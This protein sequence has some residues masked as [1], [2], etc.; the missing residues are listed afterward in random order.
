M[1]NAKTN[2]KICLLKPAVNERISPSASESNIN[3]RFLYMIPIDIISERAIRLP[4]TAIETP[5]LEDPEI[6]KKL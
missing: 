6:L 3:L 1:K 2:I 5:I 4:Y